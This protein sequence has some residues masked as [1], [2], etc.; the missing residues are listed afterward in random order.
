M[1]DKVKTALQLSDDTF[2]DEITSMIEE[3]KKDMTF[4][5]IDEKTIS[6]AGTDYSYEQAVVLYCVYRFEVLHGSMNRAE[7][8]EKIY[9]EQKRM[10]GMAS[11]YTTW[12]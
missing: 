11:G 10:L 1:L 2:D 3:A 9:N 4:A 6:E 5:G 7:T 8:L 12:S